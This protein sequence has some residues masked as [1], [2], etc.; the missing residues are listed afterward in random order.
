MRRKHRLRPRTRRQLSWLVALLLFWQQVALAAYAC[1][2]APGTG[3]PSMPAPASHAAL[4]SDCGSMHAQPTQAP[5]CQAHC[6]ADH[7]AQPEART[8]TVP[9]SLLAALPAPLP[10]LPMAR[11]PRGRA[12]ERSYRLRAPPPPASLLFCSLL[13]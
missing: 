7:A 12:S 11:A 8:H 9:P 10:V 6:Q 4:N 2:V 13:I 3:M 5:M 1:S